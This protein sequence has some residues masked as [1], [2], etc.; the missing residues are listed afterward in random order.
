MHCYSTP[1]TPPSSCQR[2]RSPTSCCSQTQQPPVCNI[3]SETDVQQQHSGWHFGVNPVVSCFFLTYNTIW[4]CSIG[5][6]VRAHTRLQTHHIVLRGLTES[7]VGR[8]DSHLCRG[9][10]SCHRKSHDSSC[11]GSQSV[12]LA[13]S[14]VWKKVLWLMS[15][16]WDHSCNNYFIQSFLSLRPESSSSSVLRTISSDFYIKPTLNTFVGS[17][18]LFGG[19]EDCVSFSFKLA[20]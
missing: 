18:K 3:P 17:L 20:I 5:T 10:L 19:D 1:P 12:T 11:C 7:S 14:N 6:N 8:S 2:C 9:S 4:K 13:S 16:P 15:S